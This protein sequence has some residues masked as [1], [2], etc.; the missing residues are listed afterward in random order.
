MLRWTTQCF[1]TTAIGELFCEASL[2][3]MAA[4]CKHHRQSGALR[5]VCAP[6]QSNPATA[7]IANSVPTWDQVQSADDHHF[8]LHGSLKAIHLMSWEHPAVNS[9]KHLPLNSMC[10]EI[11]DLIAE[12]PILPLASTD[13]LSLPRPWEPSVTYL[14]LRAPL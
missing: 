12:V 7:R 4:I 11:S 8:L 14:A 9:A 1:H 13:S 5:L 3:P 10:H 6:S 2:P